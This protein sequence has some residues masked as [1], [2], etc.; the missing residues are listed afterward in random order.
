MQDVLSIAKQGF[1][2]TGFVLTMMLVIEYLNVLT[3]GNWD[4]II[5]RWTWGQ[6]ALCAFLGATPGCLG[7][8]AA[9]S[10]YLHRVVTIGALAAA[11]VATCG[12]EAFVMLALFPRTALVIFGALFVGGA[13]TGIVVDLV[14]GARRTRA[15]AHLSQ[16]QATH[17]GHP[18]CIPF[19]AHELL[20]Q[21]R[22]CSPHRGWLTLL[23]VAFLA[24]VLSGVIGHDHAHDAADT[25]AAPHTEHVHHDGECDHGHTTEHAPWDW[26]RVTLV[27]LGGIALLIV[28]SVPDHFLDEHLWRHLVIVHGWRV[29]LWTFGALAVT[30]LL[31]NSMDVG[32]AV[33]AHGLPVLLVACLVGLLPASGPHLVFVTLYA[34][35]ALPLSTLVA[36]CIVQDGHGL[37]PT[38]AHSRRAFLVVKAV[39]LAIG[40]GIGLAG[41]MMGW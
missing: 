31:L 39:K 14:C 16:Y 38:L 27:I 32:K 9:A 41:W 19:S 29:L 26:V 10:L 33:A 18:E 21:W 5:G 17:T 36:N 24:G 3:R 37:I 20:G 4:R 13:V 1:M 40:L 7:A 15:T 6:S 22:R 8:Y 28:A 23:L 34:E 25:A 11:M 30:Q 35:G 2:I 12:D